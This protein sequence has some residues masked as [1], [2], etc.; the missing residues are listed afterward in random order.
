MNEQVTEQE[1][2]AWVARS[3][4]LKHELQAKSHELR[5]AAHRSERLHFMDLVNFSLR[6]AAIAEAEL[7]KLSEQKKAIR[8]KLYDVTQELKACYQELK[9]TNEDLC[10]ALNSE[11]LTPDQAKELAITLVETEHPARVALAELLS[12]IYGQTVKPWDLQSRRMLTVSLNPSGINGVGKL[13]SE[14]IQLSAQAVMFQAKFNELATRFASLKAKFTR[15]QAEY[16]E[17]HRLFTNC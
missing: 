3:I 9:Y 6:K 7:T 5:D 17:S 13:S 2:Q 4:S 1:L 16:E 14:P 11:R 15:L 10:N 12:A 8:Q